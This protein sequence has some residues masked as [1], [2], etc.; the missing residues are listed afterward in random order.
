MIFILGA[1]DVGDLIASLMSTTRYPLPHTAVPHHI[2]IFLSVEM[3][4]DQARGM[5]LGGG[6]RMVEKYRASAGCFSECDVFNVTMRSI[7]HPQIRYRSM[8][9][10]H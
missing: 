3:G 8:P 1:Q 9:M 4:V 5:N 6:C 10:L 2:G 7:Q